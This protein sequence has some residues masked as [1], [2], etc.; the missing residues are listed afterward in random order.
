MPFTTNKF[1]G[2]ELPPNLRHLAQPPQTIPADLGQSVARLQRIRHWPEIRDFCTRL[3]H[4]TFSAVAHHLPINTTTPMPKAT[5]DVVE[6]V[7]K[8]GWIVR[9]YCVSESE[10]ERLG[11]PVILKRGARDWRGERLTQESRKDHVEKRTEII[12]CI[13]GSSIYPQSA[14]GGAYRWLVDE[15]ANRLKQ[16]IEHDSDLQQFPT[17]SQTRDKQDHKLHVMA[18]TVGAL[19]GK[20]PAETNFDIYASAFGT[21]TAHGLPD[22]VIKSADDKTVEIAL[23]PV[24]S[25]YNLYRPSG[26]GYSESEEESRESRAAMDARVRFASALRRLKQVARTVEPSIRIA[27]ESLDLSH[28]WQGVAFHSVVVSVPTEH[29]TRAVSTLRLFLEREAH[30]ETDLDF[31]GDIEGLQGSDRTYSLSHLELGANR[32]PHVKLPPF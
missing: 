9:Y 23:R 12:G 10:Q 29:V 4:G 15:R 1:D 31:S 3:H 6:R 30:R 22:A 25:T 20:A 21:L 19:H 16:R 5:R 24:I 18:V 27:E 28:K 17:L 26:Y 13:L 2:K 8:Q 7:Q 14:L 32:S 11:I